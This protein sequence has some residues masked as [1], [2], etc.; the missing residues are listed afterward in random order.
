MGMNYSWES[1]RVKKR[2]YAQ[3]FI[4]GA[5]FAIIILGFVVMVMNVR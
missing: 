5:L 3:G 2:K 1:E 4:D